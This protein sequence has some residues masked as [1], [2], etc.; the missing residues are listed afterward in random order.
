MHT[1]PVSIKNTQTFHIVLAS[2]RRWWKRGVSLMWI[3]THKIKAL[4]P[5]F[6][7]ERGVSPLRQAPLSQ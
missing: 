5:A 6:S 2:M 7:V 4:R 3:T 1:P